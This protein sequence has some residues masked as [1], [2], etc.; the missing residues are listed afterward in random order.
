MTTQNISNTSNKLATHPRI[1]IQPDWSVNLKSNTLP[2]D[3]WLEFKPAS[4]QIARFSQNVH[5]VCSIKA[6]TNPEAKSYKT[7]S[8][9]H[10]QSVD[11]DKNQQQL[12]IKIR[13]T[14]FSHTFQG[15]FF[16]CFVFLF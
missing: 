7:S 11:I 16:F 2:A 4:A 5:G 13:D 14:D 6:L 3:V 10:F 12:R 15:K 9:D 1:I 8:G